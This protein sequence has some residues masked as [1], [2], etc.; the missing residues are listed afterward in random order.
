MTPQ[1]FFTQFRD[2]LKAIVWTGTSTKVFG[3]NVFVVPALPAHMLYQI[4]APSCY[5]CPTEMRYHEEHPNIIFQG[6]EIALYIE[7]V[8]SAFGE[9]VVLSANRTTNTSRGAGIADV[10]REL[11]LNI[12]KKTALTSKI[13]IVENSGVRA[14]FAK[15]NIPFIY[16][17]FIFSVMLNYF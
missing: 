5:I 1:V 10:S 13:Y 17:T 6:F 15:G 2:Y 3:D 7:N 16:Q 4:V 8:S 14:Q 11:M 12:N 9:G